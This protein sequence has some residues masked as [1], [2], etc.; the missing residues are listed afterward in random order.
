MAVEV[1]V[2][3]DRSMR[4]GKLLQGFVIP[5]ARHRALSEWQSEI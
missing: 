1:E 3:V 2:V 4:G 5:E